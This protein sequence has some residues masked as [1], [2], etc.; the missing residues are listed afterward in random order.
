MAE[1]FDA[2]N[3]PKVELI[4]HAK[5]ASSPEGTPS[6][7]EGSSEGSE[8]RKVVV[9]KKKSVPPGAAQTGSGSGSSQ[10][11]T[12]SG[13]VVSKKPQPK[14]VVHTTAQEKGEGASSQETGEAKKTV[15]VLPVAPRPAVA[16]GIV[17]GKPVGPSPSKQEKHKNEGPGTQEELR[18]AEKQEKRTGER[19][20]ESQQST[21]GAEKPSPRGPASS[22]QGTPSAT[23]ANPFPQRPAAAAGRVGGRPVGAQRGMPSG[24]SG[25][26][27]RPGAPV[28]GFPGRDRN[29]GG[30]GLPREGNRE[31]SASGGRGTPQSR[32]GQ[33]PGMP[34]R[35]SGGS[36]SGAPGRPLSAPVVP[37]IEGKP[38]AKKTFKAK[39]TVYQR[40]EEEM[41]EKLL[42][43]KKKTTTVT[44]PVP[45]SIEITEVISV[46]ELA[47]KMNL[48]ASDLIQKLMSMGMMVTINQQI[49]AETAVILASEY[50]CEV[51]VVS[52]Y[53]ETV[54]ESEA[55]KQEDLK[56]RPPIVTVMGHVD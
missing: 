14:V 45:K 16:A 29:A 11:S 50:G 37:L 38:T 24:R 13:G 35:V 49:D 33:R 46:A 5:S 17:G 18:I 30:S 9:V 21:G 39:K 1:E 31:S 47:K 6:V 56:P 10:G 20:S 48:K 28:G 52:L 4:K 34:A 15:S 36:R 27:G 51:K 2:T 54:I 7:K 12:E 55:D 26:S 22:S 43:L 44:N 42:Q 40:K 25:P 23:N 41:E 8:K 19:S 3:K 32:S 53:D